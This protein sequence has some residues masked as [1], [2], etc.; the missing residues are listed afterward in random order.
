MDTWRIG[1]EV[2]EESERIRMKEKKEIME[3]L[4]EGT[5]WK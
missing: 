3:I 1:K 2:E 4:K 5:C